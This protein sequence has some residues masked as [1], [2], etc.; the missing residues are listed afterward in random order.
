M[1]T[2]EKSEYV[3]LILDQLGKIHPDLEKSLR[4]MKT[5]N[6][7]YL[8]KT[9]SDLLGTRMPKFPERTNVQ[10]SRLLFLETGKKN[11]SDGI[12]QPTL[13]GI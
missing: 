8:S 6:I 5:Q 9:I 1:R 11:E 13:P 2:E 4:S 7:I 12:Y 10:K 3:S